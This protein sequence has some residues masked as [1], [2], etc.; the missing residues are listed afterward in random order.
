MKYQELRDKVQ[1]LEKYEGC[2]KIDRSQLI[3]PAYPGQ[4][5]LSFTEYPWLQEYGRYTDFDHDFAFSTVQSC[6]RWNDIHQA[7]MCSKL[8]GN[9]R[10]KY[11]GVFEMADV[12]G[13]ISLL[14]RTPD[15]IETVKFARETGIPFDR[16]SRIRSFDYKANEL[17]TLQTTTLVN[18][19]TSLGIGKDRIYPSYQLGGNISKITGGKYSFDFQTPEDCVGAFSF[20]EQGIENLISDKTRDTL[21]S[22]GLK[23]ENGEGK[24]ATI[25]TPWGYRNEINV[26]IGTK[27]RPRF[28][29]VGTL[30]RFLW[31]PIYEGEQ[32]VGLQDINDVVSI[33]ALGLERLCMVVNGLQKVQDIDCIKPVYDAMPNVGEKVLVGESL[34]AIHRIYADIKTYEINVPKQSSRGEKIKKLARTILD[35]GL[36]L[37]QIAEL[38]KINAQCQPWHPELEGTVDFCLQEIE[39]FKHRRR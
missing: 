37:K 29:D 14:Q 39:G 22:V 21:L 32:I 33:G 27:K 13:M 2:V 36:D 15:Y 20:Y 5:N 18:F 1:N 4:F 12:S 23:R 24:A 25:C 6:I 19:L 35:S 7:A 10:W 16:V 8:V 17:Q 38:L 34:R 31:K 3:N 9:E 30:E 26:N 28:V 11:L